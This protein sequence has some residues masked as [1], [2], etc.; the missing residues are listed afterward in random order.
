MCSPRFTRACPLL[1]ATQ[2][3]LSR[4]LLSDLS[5]TTWIPA[6]LPP[7][8][9]GPLPRLVHQVGVDR[10]SLSHAASF[11]GVGSCSGGAE[12]PAP[13]SGSSGS[14]GGSGGPH[15]LTRVELWDVSMEG[16]TGEAASF[17][18][19]WVGARG[20]LCCWRGQPGW[21]G[22][23]GCCRSQWLIASLQ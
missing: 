16:F 23:A 19:R 1:C 15:S 2:A 11:G 9:R 22:R 13:A 3:T 7:P 5:P 10:L 20:C 21:R 6:H 12:A 14:L 17:L 18:G 8:A 4:L